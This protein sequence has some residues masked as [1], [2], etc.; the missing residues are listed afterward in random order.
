MYMLSLPSWITDPKRWNSATLGNIVLP[1]ITYLHEVGIG[2]RRQKSKSSGND[3]GNV[4]IQGLE[5]PDFRFELLLQTAEDER[6]WENVVPIFLPRKQPTQ[7]DILAVYHPMLA[8][9]QISACLVVDLR[10]RLPN[11]GN[12]MTA[13]IDC[14]AVSPIKT[15]ATKT[16]S[17]KGLGGKGP[18]GNYQAPDFVRVNPNI[19]SNS[20]N[21]FPIQP[22]TPSLK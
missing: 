6:G 16:L 17:S 3:Y 13:I 15:N 12:S 21:G 9:Y 19:P 8:Y 14:V 4:L 5:I 11:A 1:G 20:E 2:L 22:P 10:S 7:R 18:G